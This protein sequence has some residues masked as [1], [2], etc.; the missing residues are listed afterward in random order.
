M[1]NL[2]GDDGDDKKD[3]KPKATDK[4]TPEG[5][6]L[7]RSVRQYPFSQKELNRLKTVHPN[8][9]VLAMTVAQLYPC[10][11]MFG[12]RSHAT[13]QKII[14][15]GHSNATPG[16]SPHNAFPSQAIDLVPRDLGS[17][18]AFSYEDKLAYW[19]AGKV[20]AIADILFGQ[21]YIVCGADWKRSLSLNKK[22]LMD[23]LHFEIAYEFKSVKPVNKMYPDS[24]E[25]QPP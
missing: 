15:A 16:K 21:G 17:G 11:V 22:G 8:L 2:F 6:M 7:Y 1:F 25:I 14:D 18:L 23:P 20:M 9:Q 13:Q 19:F 24:G 10:Y 5:S 3:H 4:L 12:Y